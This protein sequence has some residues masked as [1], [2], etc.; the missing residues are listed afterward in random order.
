MKTCV[1]CKETKVPDEFHKRTNS[2]DGLQSSCKICN[3]SNTRAWMKLNPDKYE[4][5]WKKHTYGD[6][7]II[8]RKASKYGVSLETLQEMLR[9][10]GGVCKICGRAPEKGLVIDHCHTSTKVRG[11][12]CNNCNTAIGLLGDSIYASKNLVK[13]L[14]DNK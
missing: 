13:Y 9:I 8:K 4:N 14:E 7:A 3:N 6:L 10:A 11:L 12:I 2:K 5:T 1:N